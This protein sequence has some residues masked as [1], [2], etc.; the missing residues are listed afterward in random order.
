MA[1]VIKDHLQ[2]VYS[3]SLCSVKPLVKQWLFKLFG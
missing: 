3:I 1:V 2:I